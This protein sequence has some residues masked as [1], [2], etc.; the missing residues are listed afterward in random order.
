MP[1]HA[2]ILICVVPGKDT[3]VADAVSKID[4]V[5]EAHPVAGPYDVAAVVEVPSLGAL[6]KAVMEEVRAIDGVTKSLTLIAFL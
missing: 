5:K 1:V 3:E 2:Y 6:G 4:G